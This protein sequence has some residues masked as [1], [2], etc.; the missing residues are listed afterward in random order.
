MKILI[1][2]GTGFIGSRLADSLASQ[3]H[4][5]LV[6]TRDAERA[7]TGGGVSAVEW[8]AKS[9][10]GILK[11]VEWA[12]AVVNL[13]GENVA[14]GRWTAAKKRR[15]LDSRVDA[16][17]GIVEAIKTANRK[18]EVLVN[19]S[20]VGYYGF[21]SNG[22][23]LDEGSRAGDGFLADVCRRWEEEAA[24]VEESG[25]RL[26]IMRI[27]VVLGRGGGALPKMTLPFKFF[28]G[29]HPGT[30]RQ[31]V[32]W[33]H[34]ED[35]VGLIEY[36]IGN[37][38]VEGPVN[39]TA[40]EPVPM[41]ELCRSIGCSLNRRSWAHVPGFV[42]K[43]ALGEMSEIILGSARVLPE[44]AKRSGYRFEFP[45]AGKALNDLLT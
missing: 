31:Y 4:D 18:P 38:S 35:T 2:G 34:I 24:K 7:S 43:L 42:L 41:R 27:G 44:S 12:D 8:D 10:A 33:I 21:S 30:G 32:P 13:A 19:A 6:A 23:A 36:A 28:G 14:E 9:P 17:R 39:V 45:E 15:I 3:G 29:G 26:A 20:A 25:V 37:K 22:T 11:S 16:T 5:V 40:P 1:A